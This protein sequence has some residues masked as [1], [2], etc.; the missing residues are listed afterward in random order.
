MIDGEAADKKAARLETQ[1]VDIFNRYQDQIGA[2][3]KTA[4]E[5]GLPTPAGFEEWWPPEGYEPVD[6]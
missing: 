2:N 5:L 6:L 4:E 1:T 3:V